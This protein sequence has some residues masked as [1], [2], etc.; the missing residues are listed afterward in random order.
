VGDAAAVVDPMTGEGIA[1]A[2]DT[3]MLAAEAQ[4]DG[5]GPL[6][7]AARYHDLVRQ[8]LRPDFVLARFLSTVLRSP[9]RTRAA[10]RVIDAND[11]C[12]RNFARWMF[13][14]YPRAILATPR[15]WRPDM[16]AAAGAYRT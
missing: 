14:D 8:Q 2:L 13:E 12:R 5:G 16:L 7:V 1:Q 4:A 15:R 9:F 3:G 10:L 11:W 6:A